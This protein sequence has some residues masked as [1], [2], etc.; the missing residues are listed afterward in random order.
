MAV[1]YLLISTIARGQSGLPSLT[2]AD[3]RAS[4]KGRIENLQWM[5]PETKARALDKLAHHG[6]PRS[7]SKKATPNTSNPRT[8]S[9]SGKRLLSLQTERPPARVAVFS[10]G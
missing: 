5:S 4:M 1:V 10:F 6:T 7:T 2:R 8:A 3:L 9:A